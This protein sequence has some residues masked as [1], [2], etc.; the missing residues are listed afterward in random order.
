MMRE[1]FTVED[2]LRY[3]EGEL[4]ARQAAELEAYVA[5]NR[6][7]R[8]QLEKARH[9]VG[10][11]GADEP[12]LTDV[13][14]GPSVWERIDS[15][16]GP[17]KHRNRLTRLFSVRPALGYGLVGAAAAC[18]FAIVAVPEMLSDDP[19]SSEW[20]VKSTAVASLAGVEL[21]RQTELDGERP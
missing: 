7:A 6:D 14:V 18:I 11:L 17:T 5:D 2:Y 1:R 12:D 3:V 16:L 13:D 19:E 9:L 20:R 8:E 21:Y 10:Q 4:P 15:E